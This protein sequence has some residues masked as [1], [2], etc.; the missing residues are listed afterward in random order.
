MKPALTISSYLG[1][2]CVQKT[3]RIHKITAVFSALLLMGA[4]M[5]PRLSAASGYA[6]SGTQGDPYLVETAAQLNHMRNNLTAHYKLA[7]T[8][9]MGSFGEFEPIGSQGSEF[10]GSFTCETKPDGTPKFAIKNLKVY[11][12]AGEKY[13]H[14][15][16]SAASY[17]D[18]V[19][20]KNKWQA[21]LFGYTNG[22][23]LTN[24]AVLN[25]DVTNTVVGQ[26]SMN[27]DWS[28][29]P[30]QNSTDQSTGILV[31]SAENTNITGCM[32]SGK[33]TSKSNGTGGLIG[34]IVG[35]SVTNC[36]S[37][38]NV[39]NSGYWCTGGLI[40]TCD[41]NVSNCFATGNVTGGPTESTTGGLIGQVTEGSTALVTSCYST[42]AIGPETNGFSLVGFRMNYRDFTPS[43][44][45]N[46]YTTGK[47]LGYSQTQVGDMGPTNNNYILS[48]SNGR[49]DGFQ[50]ATAAE[51]KSGLASS[52]DWDVSGDM[53]KL[54]NVAVIQDEGVY[55]PGSVSDASQKAEQNQDGSTASG[56]V[57]SQT[58]VSQGNSADVQKVQ[59][60]IDALPVS[61]LVTY[62]DKDAVK[63]AKKAYDALSA[64]MKTQLT[65]E[66]AAKLAEVCNA[67]EPL[68]LKNLVAALKK[69]PDTDKLTEA[70]RAAVE[71]LYDDYNF[72][73]QA[74]KDSMVAQYQEKLLA[75]IRFF[76]DQ[77][78]SAQGANTMSTAEVTLVVVLAAL[79]V[80]VLTFNVVWS[81]AIIRKS[82]GLASKQ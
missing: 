80:L 78:V 68:I 46:C 8:I 74:A 56:D 9:D 11:N 59:A 60:M 58:D 3:Q 81:V 69:L 79:V 10:S 16:G 75:A 6:G 51:I 71:A 2:D 22:A 33:V 7:N 27:G 23:A 57:A 45:T 1:G 63:A 21:G 53:P 36:Y 76:E 34:Y 52:A 41:V 35:G 65:A 47:V 15:I 30:G 25:A 37:T 42:G 14:K 64:D 73:S 62:A 77:P 50:S 82:R 32:S 61:Q 20:G 49:Q 4:V 39:T 18:Y 54:K 48:G 44:M 43:F 26:N 19:E 38:A 5:T 24:I 67:M 66:S 12:H 55:V 31:G 17:V 28:I 70:D 29:N 72:L 13:G 40:G